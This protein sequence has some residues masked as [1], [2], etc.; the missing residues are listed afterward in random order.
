[1]N[2]KDKTLIPPDY[3]RCQCEWLGGSFMT[4]GPR[5]TVRC[6]KKPTVI[7]QEAK[8]QEGY[9]VAGSMS[10][11]D[12]HLKVMQETM[13]KRSSR[14]VADIRPRRIRKPKEGDGKGD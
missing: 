11:C 10:L 14:I 12:E 5:P 13:G 8:P 6:E 4:L 9:T 1:M 7:V 2:D 3:D